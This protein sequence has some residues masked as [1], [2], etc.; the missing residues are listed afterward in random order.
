MDAPVVGRLACLSDCVFRLRHA[1][2]P[3][4]R[5][6]LPGS[7]LWSAD[8]VPGR[9]HRRAMP[10]RPDR[11]AGG[12]AHFDGLAG[13]AVAVC[14]DVRLEPVRRFRALWVVQAYWMP[15][16]LRSIHSVELLLDSLAYGWLLAVLFLS[17]APAPRSGPVEPAAIPN[18]NI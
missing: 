4:G 18:Y 1:G 15:W 14:L 9:G 7:S 8:A 6:I 5:E 16:T 3:D 11:S 17:R 10:P 2:G 13:I 12:L